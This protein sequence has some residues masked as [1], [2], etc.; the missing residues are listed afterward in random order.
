MRCAKFGVG[1][2]KA[3][4]L[5]WGDPSAMGVCALPIYIYIYIYIIYIYIYIYVCA[6]RCAKL[7]VAVFKASMLDLGIHLV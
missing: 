4:R 3:S 1:V 5:L 6:M 2:C 7:G